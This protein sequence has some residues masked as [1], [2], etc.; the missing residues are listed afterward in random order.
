MFVD[1]ETLVKGASICGGGDET[2]RDVKVD[3]DE[4]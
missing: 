1:K 2:G 4:H 3:K